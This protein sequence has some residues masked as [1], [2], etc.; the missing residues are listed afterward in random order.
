MVKRWALAAALLGGGAAE[1]AEWRVDIFGGTAS[2]FG[3]P[4]AIQQQGERDLEI[5]ADWAGRSFD[6]P[7]YY[8]V[9]LSR[10]SGRFG[11]SLQL[12]HHKLYLENPPPEIQAFSVSHGYNLLTLEGGWLLRGFQLSAGAGLVIAHPESTVRGL[13]LPESGGYHVTGPTL[14]VGVGRWWGLGTHFRVGAETRFTASWARMP[15]A[16]GEASVPD[17]SVH[18][19]VGMGYRFGASQ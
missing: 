3:S 2:S 16:E 6:S 15:V 17:R 9:R 18:F 14:L 19:L 11:L 10:W 8:A 4:L 1:G 12:V 5:D 7:I 13:T